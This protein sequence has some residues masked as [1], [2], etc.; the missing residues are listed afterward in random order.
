MPEVFKQDICAP[1]DYRFV[2]R[3]LLD[4]GLL[5]PYRFV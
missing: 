2:A 3:L 4:K 5:L 1:F